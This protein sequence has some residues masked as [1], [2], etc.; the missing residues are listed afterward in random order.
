MTENSK[1][2]VNQNDIF[3]YFEMIKRNEPKSI[4]D[5]GMF[6]K[7]IGAVSRQAME[8]EIPQDIFLCGI[9]IFP[10]FGLSVYEMIFNKINTI[11][12]ITN[13]IVELSKNKTM[14]GQKYDL[15]ML[16]RLS[17]VLLKEQEQMLWMYALT[18]SR[19]VF[20][21][22]QAADQM[23]KYGIINGYIDVGV[24]EN[25]KYALVQGLCEC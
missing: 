1:I 3:V 20:S 16:M 19:L 10:E 7:R 24:D 18:H 6:L 14:K 22:A 13:E 15:T 2:I 25:H 4:L 17:G 5:I 21:D 11:G 23:I 12:E 9:D 8:Y